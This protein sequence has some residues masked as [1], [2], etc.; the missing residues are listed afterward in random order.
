MIG[1]TGSAEQAAAA[2]AT[3]TR[4]RCHQRLEEPKGR[5][6]VLMGERV[7][8]RCLSCYE[9]SYVAAA[10]PSQFLGVFSRTP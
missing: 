1:A 8:S 9:V 5:G 7:P 3:A 10:E 4:Q 2:R 6:A